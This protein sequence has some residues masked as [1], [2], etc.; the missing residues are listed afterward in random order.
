MR[1]SALL[2]LACAY[3]ACSKKV[4]LTWTDCS[5]AGAHGKITSVDVSPNPPILGQ[6]T[7]IAGHAVLDKAI[8]D[9]QLTVG[10]SFAG[11]PVPVRPSVLSACGSTEVQLPLN[12][13]TILVNGLKCP[14][15][16]GNATLLEIVNIPDIAPLGTY[17][18]SLSGIDQD[19][20]PTVCVNLHIKVSA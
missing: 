10:A 18:A 13:G 2:V 8:T 11:L 6:N 12:L 16:K 4:S 1:I 9:G 3:M 5:V 19:S 20:E 7:T 17:V 15:A 14:Q